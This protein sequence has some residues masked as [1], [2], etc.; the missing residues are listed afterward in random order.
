MY[1][2]TFLLF[3]FVVLM[4][5]CVA[6]LSFFF[7]FFFLCVFVVA[8]FVGGRGMREPRIF[9]C[10]RKAARATNEQLVIAVHFTSGRLFLSPSQL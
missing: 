8:M 3:L 10:P 2:S 4:A 6:F 7:P 5:L 9:P 1:V